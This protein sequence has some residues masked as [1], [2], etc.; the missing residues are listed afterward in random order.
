MN[1]L[2][3]KKRVGQQYMI[4]VAENNPFSESY[5]NALKNIAKSGNRANFD[6]TYERAVS[7]F[8]QTGGLDKFQTLE[9]ESLLN[10]RNS[11]IE[12][13]TTLPT[14]SDEIKTV[15]ESITQLDKRM[16]EIRGIKPDPTKAA[17]KEA[18]VLKVLSNRFGV[19]EDE[20]KKEGPGGILNTYDQIIDELGGIE[21][22]T[23]SE[24]IKIAKDFKH[25]E[26]EDSKWIDLWRNLWPDQEEKEEKEEMRP[27]EK[28]YRSLL[29][30]ARTKTNEQRLIQ[31]E[32]QYPYLKDLKLR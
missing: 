7:N 22:I 18:K 27:E 13:L 25:G 24:A 1:A 4:L 17:A 32:T 3:R 14:T 2:L 29:N 23:E 19:S 8:Q 10:E 20:L 30:K 21:N 11:W 6:R 16:N 9:F 26:K 5:K 28:T 15:R 31:L 12:K